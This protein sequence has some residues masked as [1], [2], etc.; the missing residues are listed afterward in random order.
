MFIDSSPSRPRGDNRSDMDMALTR[1]SSRNRGDRPASLPRKEGWSGT[2]DSRTTLL[3]QRKETKDRTTGETLCDDP[4]SENRVLTET[5]LRVTGGQKLFSTSRRQRGECVSLA[6]T[7]EPH[8]SVPK[9]D[10]YYHWITVPRI[11][12]GDYVS[13]VGEEIS[14]DP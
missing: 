9:N 1:V 3:N 14:V 8:S 10:F 7:V 4:G 13:P 5:D 11:S 2:N 12:T 6:P